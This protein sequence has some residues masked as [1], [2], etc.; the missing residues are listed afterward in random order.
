MDNYKGQNE[1]NDVWKKVIMVRTAGRFT[2]KDIISNSFRD[3]I[4]LHGD[5]YYGDDAAIIGGLAWLG[6][7]AVTVIAHNKSDKEANYGMPLPEG[8][9]KS[10]RLMQ[11]A[12][13]FGRPIVNIIDT[14]GAYPGIEAEERGQAEAIARNLFIMSGLKVPII[15]LVIGE[16]GS[17]GALALS[18]ANKLFMLDNAIFSVVSPEGCASILWKD[19]SLAAKAAMHLKLTAADLYSMG[20]IDGIIIEKENR[21]IHFKK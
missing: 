18:V 8:Y 5:R 19:K 6:D 12:E 21:R 16:G 7:R 4:E 2:G 3:F 20:V 1:M 9:R 10:L 17:G 14:P 15:S 11:Q 13:K